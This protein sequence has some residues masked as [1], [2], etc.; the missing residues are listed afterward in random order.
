MS[1]EGKDITIQLLA[2]PCGSNKKRTC[3]TIWATGHPVIELRTDKSVKVGFNFDFTVNAT[4]F[5]HFVHPIYIFKIFFEGLTVLLGTSFI[6]SFISPI[7]HLQEMLGIGT[8]GAGN[9]TVVYY[10]HK[11][12]R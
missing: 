2:G 8:I 9:T 7:I 10:T 4:Y 3:L 12:G 1:E 5:V 6:H 11:T